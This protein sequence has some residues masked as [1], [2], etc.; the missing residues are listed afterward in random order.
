M[1]WY[2]YMPVS[3]MAVGMSEDEPEDSDL[4]LKIEN[5]KE[6]DGPGV[7]PWKYIEGGILRNATKEEQQS[8]AWLSDYSMLC[9]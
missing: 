2:L 6:K 3:K 7:D 9:G 4:F 1:S 5:P 8:K